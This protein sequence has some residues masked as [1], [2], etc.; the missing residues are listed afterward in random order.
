MKVALVAHHVRPTGGQ[1]RY[2][3]ELARH[4]S[5]RHE[6][7][8]VTVRAE[9]CEDVAATVHPVSVADRPVLLLQARFARRA[10][11]IVARLGCDVVHV[12]GGAVPGATVITAQYVHAAWREARE[13]Y[14]VREGSAPR[15]WYQRLVGRRAERDEWRAFRDPD[16]RAIIAVSVRT[17]GELAA[18][19]GVDAA[20]T[21]VIY[22]GVDPE[23]FDP[24]RHADARAALRRDLGL[25][26]DAPLVLLV[27]TY[28][29]K[30]LDTAIA[31]LARASTTAH[32]VVAGAGDDALA[33]RWAAAAGMAG[34]LHLLGM[35]RD[36][37]RLF[38]ASDAF[39]LPT[40]YEPFGMVIAE[41]MASRLPVVVS[42]CAGAA[43]L[44]RHGENGFV[45]EAADDVEG[46]AAGLRA[47]LDDPARRAAIGLAARSTAAAL[48]WTH[49]AEQT[50]RV[51]RQALEAGT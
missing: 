17:A 39:V 3:L 40:R 16:V 18:H 8:L 19:Y 31:A 37:E 13:R 23:V 7:H 20:R 26:G 9:G 43:E 1:D 6:I 50:E 2:L 44:I 46:F 25:A 10:A 4:L 11:A 30:G 24:T 33:R 38:A 42:A 27:G 36:V 28:A 15:R 21:A 49:V 14:D 47:A 32:L 45:V 5:R 22:N 34:R 51:Y 29:R 12:V 48:A 41:A 35:R